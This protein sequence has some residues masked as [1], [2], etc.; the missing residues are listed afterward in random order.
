LSAFVQAVAF[1]PTVEYVAETP[2][3][4]VATTVHVSDWLFVPPA[5]ASLIV[6]V[7]I[8]SGVNE[9]VT[10]AVVRPAAVE[11]TV[12]PDA[13]DVFTLVVEAVTAPVT[14]NA[15]APAGVVNT[16]DVI[17]IAAVGVSEMND[18]VVLR[19]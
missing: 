13:Y 14:A 10:A 3:T 15:P 7:P 8:L 19:V 18:S 2:A 17:D 9:S 5:E 11:V 6:N 4:S 16:D 12:K 1:I